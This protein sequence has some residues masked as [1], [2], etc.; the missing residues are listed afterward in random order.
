MRLLLCCQL[1]MVSCVALAEEPDLG[2]SVVGLP[3]L[4][5]PIPTPAADLGALTQLGAGIFTG[6]GVVVLEGAT[7]L[8]QGPVDGLEVI[9][10]LD[11]GKTHESF[12]RL[13]TRDAL[14]IK[15]AFTTVLGLKDGI[16]AEENNP[17]PARGTPLRILAQW[18]AQGSAEWSSI[19]AS[20][21]VRD[22]SSD[23][24]FPPLPFIY[25]GSRL[26]ALPEVG[27]D[28]KTVTRE[29]FML[30]STKSLIVTWNEPDAL[31][32][33]PFPGANIDQHFEVNSGI[34]PPP[35]T[36]IRLVCRRAELPLTIHQD[37][38]GALRPDPAQAPLDDESLAAGL[39]AV[40]GGTAAPE[41]RAVGILVDAAT[42]PAKDIEV[43]SR[44]LKAA[45][46]A[47]VWVV[48]V[49]VVQ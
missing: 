32:A 6:Q 31:L 7:L 28:G 24:A 14:V 9:A 1:L 48:P 42:D 41:L 8:D 40:Y 26:V 27:A 29:H 30:E 12:M 16:P 39:T 36:A 10:C 21:L 18:K 2:N 23:R 13:T 11:G 49:W 44:I 33:S 5:K 15:V 22:R 3:E 35:S 47:K 20:C 25:T 19:D 4:S 34:A 45:R 17:K 43:R 37:A 38:D 46:E